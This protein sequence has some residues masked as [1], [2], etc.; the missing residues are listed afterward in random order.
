MVVRRNAVE[1][2]SLAPFG[3][4]SE[5]FF[6]IFGFWAYSVGC[7]ESSDEHHGNSEHFKKFKIIIF[8]KKSELK[9]SYT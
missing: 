4:S 7:H 9:I 5:F 2:K 3:I 6:L 1:A 8:F